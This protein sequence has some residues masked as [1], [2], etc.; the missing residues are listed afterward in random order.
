[1]DWIELGLR[2]YTRVFVENGKEAATANESV[3]S[4]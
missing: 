2:R 4:W 1:M 3:G